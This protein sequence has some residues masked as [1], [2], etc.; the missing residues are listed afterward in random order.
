MGCY[1]LLQGNLPNP[2]TEPGF[3][4]LQADSLPTKLQGKPV[5]EPQMETRPP[6]ILSL[7]G[8]Q[9]SMVPWLALLYSDGPG[10]NSCSATDSLWQNLG[11]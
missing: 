4:E 2:G 6:Y 5:A 7:L 10:S 8:H 9:P 11:E 1:F 3:P